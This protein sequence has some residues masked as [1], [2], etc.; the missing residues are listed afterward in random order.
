[1]RRRRDF[2]ELSLGSRVCVLVLIR[3]TSG[4]FRWLTWRDVFPGNGTVSINL[5]SLF[6]LRASN[7][8]S[9]SSLSYRGRRHFKYSPTSPLPVDEGTD[10]QYHANRPLRPRKAKDDANAT[11]NA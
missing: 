5:E 4:L 3:V 7:I 8:S 6:F 9:S 10:Q 2:G 11:F 1:M